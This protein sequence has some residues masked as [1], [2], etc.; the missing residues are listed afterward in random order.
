MISIVQERFCALNKCK[1]RAV[2]MALILYGNPEDDAHAGRI[3]FSPP[4]F[5][6]AL[7]LNICLKQIK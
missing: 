6:T 7:D 1:A 3:F 5:V 4:R 2:G